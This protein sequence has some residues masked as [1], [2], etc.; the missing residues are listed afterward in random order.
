MTHDHAIIVGL[1]GCPYCEYKSEY[2]SL[3]RD[4]I[5]NTHI[6]KIKH[7]V[8]HEECPYCDILSNYQRDARN[9][10]SKDRSPVRDHVWNTHIKSIRVLWEKFKCPF[11]DFKTEKVE[12]LSHH[13]DITH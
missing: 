7:I 10:E 3:V 2:R 1:Y 6:I 12:D 9:P 11:C 13:L 4:H 5:W 8:E